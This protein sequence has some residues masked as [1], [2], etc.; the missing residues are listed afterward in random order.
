MLIIVGGSAGSGKSTVGQELANY[1]NC[2]F[3]DADDL[4]PAANIEKMSHGIPLTDDDRW[5]WLEVVGRK[6]GDAAARSGT[7]VVACSALSKAH[8]DKIR[9][10]CAVPVLIVMLNISRP[11]LERRISS[12]KNHFM[13]A[14]MLDSQLATLQ[15]PD[16]TENAI[17]V[18]EHVSLE[19]IEDKVKQKI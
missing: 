17:V 19:N 11:E 4:H 10:S 16:E 12:R 7:A 5:G 13:K 18:D 15:L 2:S 1:L 3:I 6:G 9:A 14:D 8:R